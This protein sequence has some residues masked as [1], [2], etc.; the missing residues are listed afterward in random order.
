MNNPL[1]SIIIVNWNG[2]KIL[3]D[4]LRSLTQLDYKNWELVF[5]DNASV[6]KSLEI[7][8]KYKS[9]ISKLKIVKNDSNLGFAGGNNVGLKFAQ[10]E[11]ILLLNNDTKVSPNLLTVLARRINSEAKIGVVQ[12]KIK[13]MDKPELLD[14][15][16][17]FLTRTGFLEHWGFMEKDGIEFDSERLI[18]SAKGACMLIKKDIIEKIG[19]FDNSFGSYFEESDFCWR[20]WLLGYQVLYY[21]ET[22]IY[23]KVGFTSKKQDQVFVFYH[24]LKN[25][26][27]SMIK[28]FEMKN[29]FL[30]GGFHLFLLL[31][32]SLYYLLRMRIRQGMMVYQ[33]IFWNILNLNQT[34]Q[35]RAKVQKLRRVTDKKIFEIIMKPFDLKAMVV[36]FGKVEANFK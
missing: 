9:K 10:G 5:V 1:V 31:G 28:N 12:P 20:V 8:D 17:S 11:L 15:A 2:E 6:D 27:L 4:C 32:L 7:L 23:H 34:L 24:S 26:L 36:H 33:A 3:D 16:G 13:I 29:L 21:P 22:F 14:N 30:I 18:F 25:R 19:L 35:K